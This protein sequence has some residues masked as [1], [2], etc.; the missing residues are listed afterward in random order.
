M[1]RIVDGFVGLILLVSLI[2][3]CGSAEAPETVGQACS[4]V[5]EEWCMRA[6][7]CFP[8]GAPSQTSCVNDFVQGCCGDDGTCGATA[9]ENISDDEW[10]DCLDGFQDLSCSEIE[11]GDVPVACLAF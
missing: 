8:A 11:N 3:G 5:G 6:R 10:T 4:D 9:N 1:G 2:G 7:E